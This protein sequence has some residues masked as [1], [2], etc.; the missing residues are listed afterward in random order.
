MLKEK[1]FNSIGFVGFIIYYL[2]ALLLT[3]MPLVILDLSFWLDLIIAAAV[4][5]IPFLGSIVK[6]GI[7]VWALVIAVKSPV[8]FWI[9]LFYISFAAYF[10]I[11]L[12]PILRS[13]F[14]RKGSSVSD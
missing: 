8:D 9:I 2:I 5:A 11:E 13:F 14:I 12:F 6:L 3:V 10:F 4:L 1:L 7:Y